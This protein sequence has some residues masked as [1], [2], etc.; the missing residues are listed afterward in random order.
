MLNLL[1]RQRLAGT[2][3]I[4]QLVEIALAKK[5]LVHAHRREKA[6]LAWL[7]RAAA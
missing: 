7:H 4:T 5:E 3:L 2:L 1:R 6:L